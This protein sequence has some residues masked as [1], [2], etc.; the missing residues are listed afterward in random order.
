MLKGSF[1]ANPILDR[2]RFTLIHDWVDHLEDTKQ[3]EL[4]A[5]SEVASQCPLQSFK[6]FKTKE[7]PT[8][9][10][11]I[12]SGHTNVR[13]PWWDGSVLYGSNNAQLAKVR[14]YKDGKLKIAS[15]GLLLHDADG[16]AIS[17]DVRNSWAGVSILQ[18]LSIEPFVMPLR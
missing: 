1:Y 9:S 17:G 7:V 3:I 11:S 12:K 16:V 6:F 14:T 2:W 13:T 8:G 10:F 15:D 4:V 18:A 5:P